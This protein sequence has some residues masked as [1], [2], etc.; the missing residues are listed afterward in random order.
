MGLIHYKKC[1]STWHDFSV[2]RSLN[3]FLA[4]KLT[5]NYTRL[6]CEDYDKKMQ[7]SAFTDPCM[8]AMS[9]YLFLSVTNN[10]SVCL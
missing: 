8:L 6:E 4:C 5:T 10:S 1:Y 9:A 7:G 2:L 3:V